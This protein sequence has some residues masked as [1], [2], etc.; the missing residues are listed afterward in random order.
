MFTAFCFYSGV[1]NLNKG[2]ILKPYLMDQ[3][4]DQISFLAAPAF[5][6]LSFGLC[7]LNFDF[8]SDC[9]L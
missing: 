1:N 2:M 6:V 5:I 7:F 8:I 9:K 3:D 4:R